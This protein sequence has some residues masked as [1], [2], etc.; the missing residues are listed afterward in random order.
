MAI[1]QLWEKPSPAHKGK[2]GGYTP[3]LLCY[4]WREINEAIS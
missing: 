1:P 2:A 4:L 3:V